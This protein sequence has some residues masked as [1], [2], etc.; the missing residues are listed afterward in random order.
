M[1]DA[2]RVSAPQDLDGD[3]FDDDYET[4]M[5]VSWSRNY[6]AAEPLPLPL[7]LLSLPPYLPRH[8]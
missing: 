3:I 7:F 6:V 2:V 5:D 4:C 8:N 1:Q